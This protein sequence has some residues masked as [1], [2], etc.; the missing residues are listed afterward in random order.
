[1][2][3]PRD[4]K[5]SEAVRALVRPGFELR[6]QTGSHSILRRDDRTVVVPQHKPIRPG[7]LKGLID[8]A[9]ITVEEFVR[10]L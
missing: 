10:E 2:K 5:G 9:G 3:L 8:Q 6:R 1:M 7:T 4:I